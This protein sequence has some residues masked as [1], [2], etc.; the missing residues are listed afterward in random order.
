MKVP[1]QGLVLIYRI[2]KNNL[3]KKMSITYFRNKLH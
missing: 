2:V 3:K 1:S